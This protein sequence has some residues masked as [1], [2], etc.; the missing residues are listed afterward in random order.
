MAKNAANKRIEHAVFIYSEDQLG[1][2]FSETHPFNQKRLVLTVDLL[3]KMN[4]LPENLVVP[5]RVATDEEL[6]L[7]HDQRYIDIVKKA[8]NGELSPEVGEIGRASC[9]ERV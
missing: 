5:A 2:K 4:A 3:R 8:S 1:Y 9:R 6:L 7:A